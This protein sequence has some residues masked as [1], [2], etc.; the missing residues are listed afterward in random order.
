M[1]RFRSTELANMRLE[2]KEKYQS[3][4]ENARKEVYILFTLK[5]DIFTKIYFCSLEKYK[6]G[7]I[8]KI[9]Q[10]AKT[11]SFFRSPYS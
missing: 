8:A 2:E 3:E 10:S 6:V 7:W 11:T 1:E 9:Y 5:E 4:I